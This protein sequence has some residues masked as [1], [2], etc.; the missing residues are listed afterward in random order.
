MKATKNT[1]AEIKTQ[2][3]TLKKILIYLLLLFTSP[4]WIFPLLYF[5]YAGGSIA[6]FLPQD[7]FALSYL[8]ERYGQEFKIV[9]SDNAD[10]LGGG[11]SYRNIAAPVSNPTLEFTIEKCLARCSYYDKTDYTD[12][13]PSAVY[14]DEITRY[15]H[16]NALAFG[17]SNND[18]FTTHVWPVSYTKDDVDI[19][20]QGSKELLPVV[21]LPPHELNRIGISVE[22]KTTNEKPSQADFDH[23]A[24]IMVSIR[25]YYASKKIATKF[26]CTI[27]TSETAEN[28]NPN[29]YR[30][31]VYEYDTASKSN[32]ETKDVATISKEFVKEP[33][34]RKLQN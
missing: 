15:T 27:T 25:D 19:F 8:Q 4:L 26:Y 22:I 9:K 7:K 17:L 34:S 5:L 23:Y 12:T 18:T 28:T 32:T 1:A 30:Y 14:N 16:Q 31:Y 21:D 24:A 11:I 10:S 6:P 20:R 2:N 29:Y 13:Y 33:R 3:I